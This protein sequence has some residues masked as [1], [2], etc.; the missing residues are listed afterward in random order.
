MREVGTRRRISPHKTV[1][2]VIGS[3]CHSQMWS[4]L[5][6]HIGG[7][8]EV[9]V[10]EAETDEF[11]AAKQRDSR[12]AFVRIRHEILELRQHN[13]SNDTQSGKKGAVCV[14]APIASKEI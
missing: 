7:V 8:Q 6:L 13:S 11:N 4:T 1:L 10:K 5:T 14:K 9:A 3:L 12:P 2:H